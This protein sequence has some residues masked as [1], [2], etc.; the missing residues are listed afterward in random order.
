MS[1]P[2][3]AHLYISAGHNFFGHHGHPPSEHAIKERDAVICVAGRGIEGDRFFDYKGDYKGQI[4]FFAEEVYREL[5]AQLRV[6]PR[7]RA[8]SVFRRNVITRGLDL[9]ALYDIEF[10]LQG[11]RFR[12]MGECKPCHWMDHAFGPGA[13]D[14]LQGR[15]GLRAKIV[16]GGKLRVAAAGLTGLV[17]TAKPFRPARI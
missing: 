11:V 15:G 9:V 12:G 5:C 10:E 7:E 8:P 4:T 2:Q 1:T 16:I 6:D 14:A 13:E 17:E 3:I